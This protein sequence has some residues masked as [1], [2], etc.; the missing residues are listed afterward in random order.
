[1][2]HY[3]NPQF[4]RPDTL[5][6]DG[7]WEFRFDDAAAYWRRDFSKADALKNTI[8][9]PFP[10]E[11]PLSGIGDKD[12]HHCL[13]YAKSFTLPESFV[14]RRVLL[15]F[16]AVDYHAKVYVNGTEIGEHFGGYSSFCFDIT[17]HI[18]PENR[19]TVCVFDDCRDPKQPSGKQC[20]LYN[21]FSALYTRTSGIWQSVWLEACGEVYLD[22]VRFT[23]K[24][25]G[26]VLAAL[27]FNKSAVGYTVDLDVSFAGEPV[28]QLSET[29]TAFDLQKSFHIDDPKLWG[30]GE[31]NLYDCRLTLRKNSA[32]SDTVMTYFGIREVGFANNVF[33]LNGKPLFLRTVLDQGFYR[34]GIYAAPDDAAL[35]KDIHLAMDMGF[36]GARLHEKVFD[37]RYLYHADRLGF[38]TFGEFPDMGLSIGKIEALAYM[39][40]EWLEVLK[41]DVNHPSIVCWCPFNETS[42][43]DFF[44]KEFQDNRVIETVYHVTKQFDPTRPVFDTSGSMHASVTDVYDVHDYTQN[45]EK[46]K[47]LF[48]KGIRPHMYGDDNFPYKG[49]PYMVTEFGG[50]RWEVDGDGSNAWGY[51]QA[52]T[53]EQEFLTRFEMMVSTLLQNPDCTGFCYTQLYD[54][55]QEKNGL[56]TYDRVAKFDPTRIRS[57]VSAKAAVED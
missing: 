40:P 25:S 30:A 32:I 44:G 49:Q 38:L 13:W 15:R 56:Y 45:A 8:R 17:D 54:V 37:P 41:R 9:V 28:A 3:P 47:A 24:K 34:E 29:V 2:I 16:G 57:I 22:S 7:E 21:S 53:T 19:I 11:A 50:I 39:L 6:L 48:T 31:G 42:T 52:P 55:E 10:P 26:D 20:A 4:A 5:L 27:S 12:F 18:L 33:T 43:N 46:F 36:N 23:T 1:M 35:E 51:G 14:G